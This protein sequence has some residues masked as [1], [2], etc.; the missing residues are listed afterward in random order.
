M[1]LF[2]YVILNSSGVIHFFSFVKTPPFALSNK[3]LMSLHGFQYMEKYIYCLTVTS[4]Y[5]FQVEYASSF[6]SN[7]PPQDPF[8]VAFFK[9][10]QYISKLK[11]KPFSPDVNHC[12]A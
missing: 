3:F 8:T 12:V 5:L 6:Y 11:R 2:F 10:C 1:T 7:I 9:K 4:R